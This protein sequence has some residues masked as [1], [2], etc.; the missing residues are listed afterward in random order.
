MV[1]QS[2]PSRLVAIFTGELVN[3]GSVTAAYIFLAHTLGPAA[4]GQIEW[5]LS[6]LSVALLVA[7]G[8]LGVWCVAQVAARP[9]AAG[10][11]VAHVARLRLAIAVPVYGVLAALAWSRGGPAGTTLAVY[12][13]V[14]L[15]TPL[16]L[17]H[18]FDGLFLTRWTAMANAL[19]G[20]T[21]LLAVVWLVNPQSPPWW[22]ALAEVLGAAVT[23]AFCVVVL[24]SVLRLSVPVLGELRG[25]SAVLS[26]AWRVGAGDVA[27]GVYS[28]GG[29]IFLGWAARPLDAAWQAAAL[30]LLMSIHTGVWLYLSTL[31]PT[32]ARLLRDD[33]VG[34][35]RTVEASL[36][37]AGWIG[38]GVAVIGTLAAA[39]ILTTLFGA[40]FEA[41]VP[42][43][44]AMIWVV[45]ISWIS[46]HLRYS[47]IAAQHPE[48][49][50]Q[51]RL[52]AA[53]TTM[54]LTL[55]MV[56]R[57]RSAGAAVALLGGS[58]AHWAAAA[59]LARGVLPVCAVGR[60]LAAPIGGCVVCLALG[61][62][63]VR[64]VGVVPATLLAGGVMA[65]WALAAERDRARQLV[66][67]VTGWRGGMDVD[68]RP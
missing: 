57:F 34:W 33:T 14:L 19:R 49:E 13:F 45:P 67:A 1:P 44:R 32:L 12:G 17:Q 8:G 62:A 27:W 23:G 58:L 39:P 35:R 63:A 37:L 64:V 52:V 51:A 38:G 26:G 21:F 30:R 66:R 61:F 7:D 40:P 55:A 28:Y 56:P 29:L 11:L 42:A 53:T 20:A 5:A 65:A 60:S 59:H 41:A 10:P 24:R 9:E 16:F 46:G 22:V 47:L 31:L 54:A 68:V 48:R 50:F 3:K 15:L 18:A 43:F 2:F 6:I 36:H 4:F 25:T